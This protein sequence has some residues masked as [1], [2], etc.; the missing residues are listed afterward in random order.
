MFNFFQIKPFKTGYLPPENGHRIYFQEI[1]NPTGIPVISFHGGP[2]GGSKTEHAGI[3]NLK[4]H[5]VILFDQRGCGLSTYQD[6]FYENTIQKTV[7][8]GKRLIDYL[9][10]KEK[11]IVAGGSYGATCALLFAETYP[12]ISKKV[13]VN[14][15]FLGR[16]QDS[17]WIYK[18]SRLFYPDLIQILENEAGKDGIIN[19]YHKLIFS[20][21]KSDQ[22]KAFNYYKAYEHLLGEMD[23]Q[24]PTHQP[25]LEKKLNSF[26]IYMHYEKNHMFLKEN[27]LLHDIS[28]IA[29]IPLLIFHNRLDFC[30]PLYQAFDL[31]QAHP[32]SRLLIVADKG[33]GSKK[34][35][36]I[37]KET[38]KNE[39]TR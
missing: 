17:E 12:E 18:T 29:K 10:I 39:N 15:V 24:F 35:F 6:P 9:K 38:L 37:M 30:C 3:F 28:K 13:I 36:K 8:D 21:K 2:G 4:T 31:H 34:F 33:H 5:R 27:Q 32:K 11:I 22:A 23:I 26:R 25:I 1:G 14:C 16:K 19:Y 20:S 7:S